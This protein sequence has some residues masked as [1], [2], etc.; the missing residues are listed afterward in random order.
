M[1]PPLLKLLKCLTE[2][3]TVNTTP[4][5]HVGDSGT[6][7]APPHVTKSVACHWVPGDTGLPG[8]ETTDVAVKEFTKFYSRLNSK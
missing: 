4:P 1:S 8:N 2:S 6:N 3:P 7:V 5:N